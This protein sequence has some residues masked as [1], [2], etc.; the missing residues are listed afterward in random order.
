MLNSAGDSVDKL[1]WGTLM[2]SAGGRKNFA[3]D[4]LSVAIAEDNPVRLW[5][6]ISFGYG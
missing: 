5:W 2:N 6:G 3:E 4:D 1:G